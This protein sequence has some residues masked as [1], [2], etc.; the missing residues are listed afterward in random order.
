LP[1]QPLSKT[2]QDHALGG[3]DVAVGSYPR[4]V[5]R[6]W[7]RLHGQSATVGL[8]GGPGA[9]SRKLSNTVIPWMWRGLAVLLFTGLVQ[10]VAEPVRQFV[11]ADCFWGQKC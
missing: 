5:D 10:T 9:A 2:L 4:R 1:T 7:L 3:A 6:L 8:W 11:D